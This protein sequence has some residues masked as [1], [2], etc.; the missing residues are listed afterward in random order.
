MAVCMAIIIVWLVRMFTMFPDQYP[1]V[2]NQHSLLVRLLR[3]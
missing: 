3:G 1:M 2:V